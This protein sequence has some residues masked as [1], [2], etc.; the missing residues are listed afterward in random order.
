M[1]GNF[2][3]GGAGGVAIQG[4]DMGTYPEDREGP[5]ELPAWGRALDH[6]KKTAEK[7]GPALD[8]TPS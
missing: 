3:D 7:G 1:S 4:G 6:Q 5:R 8:I 2:Q